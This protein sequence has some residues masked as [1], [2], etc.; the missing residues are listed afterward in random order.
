L[1]PLVAQSSQSTIRGTVRD[2]TGAVI[3]GTEVVL[4]DVNTNIRA[5]VVITDE[6]GNY[7]IPELKSGVYR[8]SAEMPGFKTFIADNITLEGGQIR[9]VDVL[10]EV[11]ETSDQITVQ[12][13][14][15][16]ITTEGGS[17]NSTL[18][19]DAHKDAPLVEIS[20]HPTVML[21]TLPGI[22]G[23]GWNV[24]IAGQTSAQT[25]QS[26]D[27]VINGPDAIQGHN[28]NLVDEITVMAVNSTADSPRAATWNTISKRGDN[29]FHGAVW[30][31]HI[32]SALNAR[33]FFQPEK[34][35][36]LFH[37]WQAEVS[38]PILQ[39]KTFYHAAWYS[40]RFPAGSF[41][42][43]DVPTLQMR[44][45]DFSQFSQPLKDPLTGEP[46]PNNVIPTE[47]LNSTALKV[48]E[49]YIPEPN[50]GAPGALRQNLGWE[51]PWPSDKYQW[52]NYQW[53]IDHNLS[54]SN[55][56]F[57][58]YN[59]YRVPYI[60]SRN[61]PA[62]T[63]T[64]VR[65]YSRGIVSDT[66]V[67][68]PGVVNTF[69]F[70]WRGNYI[71]DGDNLEGVNPTLGDEAV[72]AIGLQGVNP[73]GLSGQGF[74]RM[75]ITGISSLQTS[76]GG[77]RADHFN[78]HWEDSIN[79]TI[80]RHVWK[81]GFQL[82]RFNNFD[83]L[84][85]EGT[86][87]SFRFDGSFTGVGYA[88]FLLG[89][90]N[91]SQ[92][93]NPLLPRRMGTYEL[94]LFVMDAFKVSPRL[95]LDYGLRMDI[96]GAPIVEDGLQYNWD[97]ETGN[98]IVPQEA[99]SAISPL[100]PSNINVVAGEVVPRSDRGNIRPRFGLAYRLYD[101]LVIRGGYGVFSELIP[102][103]DRINTGGPFEIAETYFNSIQ[104]GSPLFA[105][106]NP[107]PDSLQA[108]QIPSQSVSGYPLKTDNGAIHQFNLSV[109]K[110]IHETGFR[111]SYV[112]SRSRGWN[113]N[114]NINK[115]QPGL[116]DFSTDRRPYPAF[117]N[118]SIIRNDGKSNY[119]SLQLEARRRVGAVTFNATYTWASNLHNYLNTEDPY[120]VGRHWS[121]DNFLARHH[122]V[123][124]TMIELPW[125]RGRRFLSDAPRA[126]DHLVGGWT[127]QTISYL[128]TG[129]HFSP[130][131]SGSD[132][133]NTN[134]FGGLP[135]RI[136]E[137]NL[138]RGERGVERWFDSS[139]FVTPEPGKFGNSAP[140]SLVGPGVNVHHLS[141]VKRFEVAERVGV[142]Y[143]IGASNLFNHPH[144]EAPRNNISTPGVAELHQGI[145][146]WGGT[147][148]NTERRFQMKLRVE[149]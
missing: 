18:D 108:A 139:C 3:P 49:L 9:R 32:N 110:Q 101:D 67:F 112:G 116:V 127:A 115:P 113:Y 104:E 22:Q 1:G 77:L 122:A 86:Y 131:F 5:R 124:S 98:V 100:Y 38:G 35:V 20:P 111:I 63:W 118:A 27:G 141:L 10:L 31:K 53:R 40:E 107:F 29:T 34:P 13:G 82:M 103:F 62:F 2:Q 48:Q 84:V 56:L 140:N 11:G 54:D 99:L 33:G 71:L 68:S 109:E 70:G 138:P 146:D 45:G 87:G 143:S 14:A 88:D 30:Y 12:A 19:E 46:F 7:E 135:D 78:F 132:P 133:S 85:D 134:T 37:E 95:T 8:L 76:A 42:L 24:T 26:D 44:Q 81:F 114:L 72:A 57:V 17:L 69:R 102:Y 117:V 83:G 51:H 129:S 137:G 128:G 94:G 55:S 23:Q 61:L 106:P 79:W 66:H 105:F 92:R 25:T 130:Q 16:V 52:D 43:S 91:R 36:F 144:F 126:L 147:Y 75:D 89:L 59:F 21:T 65:K 50:L 39:D 6:N 121:R 148:K 123:I 136:C 58:R 90:P 28:I 142:I 60:L 64:R 73:A 93:L 97:P 80:G 96:F 41:N 125:G 120:D 149:W 74:P 119:D 15:A 145:P 4:T 47:R